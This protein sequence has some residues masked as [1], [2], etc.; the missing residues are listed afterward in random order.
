MY[1]T[2]CSCMMQKET[3]VHK[4]SPFEVATSTQGVYS[5]RTQ[6]RHAVATTQGHLH[7]EGKVRG[8]QEAAGQ[9]VEQDN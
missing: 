1:A 7:N 5:Q 4:Y 3:S 8:H 6:R 2:E 9:H